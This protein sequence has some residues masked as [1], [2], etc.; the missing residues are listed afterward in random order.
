MCQAL[1]EIMEP[2]IN[3]I[4]EQTIK[5]TAHKEAGENAANMLKSGKFSPEEIKKYIPRLSVEE[6]KSLAEGLCLNADLNH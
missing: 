6:I 3:K 1:L 5:E 2:E 4:K